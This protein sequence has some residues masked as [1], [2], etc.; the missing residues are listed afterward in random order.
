M[1][2]NDKRKILEKHI[3]Y[4][5][6]AFHSRG[7]SF[8]HLRHAVLENGNMTTSTWITGD[9]M[10]LSLCSLLTGFPDSSDGKESTCNAGDPA[11]IPRLGRFAQEG[12]S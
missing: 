6:K 9:T 4:I 11:L 12:I 10:C 1:S 3:S 2:E 5:L 7:F 8:P